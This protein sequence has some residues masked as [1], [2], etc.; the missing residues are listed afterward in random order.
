[1][2]LIC[3]C[4]Q[5]ISSPLCKWQKESVQ[6]LAFE[7]SFIR[8][9]VKI[10]WTTG[11]KYWKKW[12]VYYNLFYLTNWEV[13]SHQQFQ[14]NFRCNWEFRY[15]SGAVSIADLVGKL[16]AQHG[17]PEFISPA[18]APQ[19]RGSGRLW[20]FHRGFSAVCLLSDTCRCAALYGGN[21][22]SLLASDF[23]RKGIIT[24]IKLICQRQLIVCI[25]KNISGRSYSTLGM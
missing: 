7:L 2:S 9:Y 25:S 23:K 19:W 15:F 12:T 16:L 5:Q 10:F 24:K 6:Q 17:L 22:G 11:I 18:P 14:C 13:C 4:S 8:L 20:D 21:R 1:M 3:W